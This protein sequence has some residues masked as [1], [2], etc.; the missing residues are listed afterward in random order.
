MEIDLKSGF[1][2][3]EPETLPTK[4]NDHEHTLNCNNKYIVP[5]VFKVDRLLIYKKVMTIKLS[6]L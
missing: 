3:S 6:S 1:G 5:V 2:S 4:L